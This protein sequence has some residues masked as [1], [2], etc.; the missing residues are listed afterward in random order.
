MHLFGQDVLGMVAGEPVAVT[1]AE[2]AVGYP[3]RTL[4]DVEPGNYYAQAVLVTY[5]TFNLTT[6]H[7][8]KLPTHDRGDGQHWV[9]APGNLYSTPRRI[10]VGD[11]ESYE[12]SMSHVNPPIPPPPDTEYV[13]HIRVVSPSLSAF[14]GREMW[15]GAIVLL[16]WGFDE[17]P[18][19]RYPIMID[20]GSA[21]TS[22]SAPLP[23]ALSLPPHHHHHHDPAL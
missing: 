21:A 6:G 15:L 23:S 5:E 9:R 7:T 10:T 11:T 17:H 4:E 8:V 16:P 19:A 3:A 13:K 20:H 12:L 14:W 1:T 22:L 2:G 18:E